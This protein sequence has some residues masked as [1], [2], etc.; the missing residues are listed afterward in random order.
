[1]L[2]LFAGA[3]RS[4][5]IAWHLREFSKLHGL[6]LEME[7]WDVLRDPKSDLSSAQ[8]WEPIFAKL[9]TGYYDVL[10]LSPPCG[11]YSRARQRS[12]GKGGPVPLRSFTYPWGFP[13][14]SN[15]N[16]LKVDLANFFVKQCFRAISLQIQSSKFWLLEHP[17]DLG[18][19]KSGEVPGSIWQLPELRELVSQGG[20]TWA[21][22]QCMFEAATSKPTRLASNLLAFLPLPCSWPQF[23]P[24]RNYLGPLGTCPH[25]SHPPLVGFQNGRFLTSGAEAY[26]TLMCRYI[27]QAIVESRHGSCTGEVA[28]PPSAEERARNLL[29]CRSIPLPEAL[30]LACLLPRED[31]HK[32]TQA[33]DGGAFYAGAF[34]RGGLYGLRSAC[35]SHPF[36]IQCFTRLLRVRFPNQVFTSFG[37]FFNV[38]T[39]MHRDSRNAAFPNLL[40]ALSSF[41]GGEVWHEEP[42]GQVPRLVQGT[43]VG[44]WMSLH[45]PKCCRRIFIFIAQSP[46]PATVGLLVGFSVDCTGLQ[47]SQLCQLLGLGFVFCR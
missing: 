47:N 2:Y 35:A 26:P 43:L 8:V 30:S 20:T 31:A 23:D 46:G 24:Q 22:H 13:W 29:S 25:G 14:L 40:L 19:T 15:A 34:L 38:L 5:D 3:Q 1:M 6:G 12:L 7:E 44:C 9:E 10:I 33:D 27:A 21:I 32:A 42:G 11:T 4:G 18:R 37:I 45:P 41:T 28:A 17:E 16:Q 36:S 39:S